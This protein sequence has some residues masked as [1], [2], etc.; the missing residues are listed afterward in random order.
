[1]EADINT[2]IWK[3]MRKAFPKN[4][5]PFPTGVN[6]IKGKV[7]TNPKEKMKVTKKNFEH[8]MRKRSLKEDTKQIASINLKLKKKTKKIQVY[9][10]S[11]I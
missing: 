5:K 2:N 7:I 10:K 11:S 8:S 3:E 6:N 4:S 9:K 1:M